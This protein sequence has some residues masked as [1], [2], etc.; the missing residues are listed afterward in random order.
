MQT[1]MRDA[2]PYTQST[3]AHYTMLD[4]EHNQRMTIDVDCW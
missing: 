3:I 1:D 4:A 2:M